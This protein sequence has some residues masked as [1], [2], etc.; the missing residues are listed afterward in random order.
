[1]KAEHRKELKTNT[2]IS[3]IEKVGHGLKEGPSRRTAVI[4]G[5][6][7]LVVLLVG[8]W[9]FLSKLS[10]KRNSDRW[11]QLYAAGSPDDLDKLIEKNRNSAQGRAAQLQVAR[12]DLAS[13]LRDIYD[14]RA[15]AIKRL[16][17]A[18]ESFE[19]L[20]REFKKTPI[21]VQECLFGAAQAH[22]A[23]GEIKEAIALYEDLA[24]RFKDTPLG[25]QGGELATKLK[26][27][28]PEL[29]D[30]QKQFNKE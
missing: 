18:A 20:A 12:Q 21:L 19:T 25:E 3:A 27:K 24:K 1:M 6:V 13:G 23:A 29:E 2:L 22:E 26:N 7:L 17:K 4:G 16:K 15:D 30:L 28:S 5:I 14:D 11:K 10:D 9:M 8:V